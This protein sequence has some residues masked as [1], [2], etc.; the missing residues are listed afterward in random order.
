MKLVLIFTLA[1]YSSCLF[2]QN[3]YFRLGTEKS[4]ICFG[5]S[6][7]YNGMRFNLE[8][9]N[10]S[11]I[12]GLNLSGLSG[13]NR[14]NG[15]SVGLL[16][17]GDSVSNG[18]EIGGLVARTKYHNGLAFGTFGLSCAKLNGVGISGLNVSGDTLNGLFIGLFGVLS[19]NS[20]D[21]VSVIN[22]FAAGGGVI[23]GRMNGMA[24]SYILNMFNDQN[25]V[26]VGGINVTKEL[27]GF[28]FGLI[29]CA[30]NNRKFFRWTPLFNFNLRKK[31]K[32][33]HR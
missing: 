22:G 7:K 27:H 2:G 16:I 3:N 8:D 1:L 19:L 9:R 21:T 18:I 32:L 4:G 20:R 26:S 14:L 17:S 15:I 10:V 31:T 29:N 11:V 28:Q 6:Q 5:N 30:L 13:S 24:F 12:N 33:K 23:A 25:G